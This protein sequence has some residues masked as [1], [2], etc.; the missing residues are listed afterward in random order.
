[1]REVNK[2]NR[3]TKK[4]LKIRVTLKVTFIRN[5]PEM[6]SISIKFPITRIDIN[7]KILFTKLNSCE[8]LQTKTCRY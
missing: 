5:I 2:I 1:M 7:S 6:F 8:T 4:L 3:I